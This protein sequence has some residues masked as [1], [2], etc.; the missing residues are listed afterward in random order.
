MNKKA[1][2]APAQQGLAVLLSEK[3]FLKIVRILATKAAAE[4]NVA[5]KKERQGSQ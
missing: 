1:Q 3:D 2:I 5:Q 4:I